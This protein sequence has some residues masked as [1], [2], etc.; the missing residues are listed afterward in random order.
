M[1]FYVRY[2]F[3]TVLR[4]KW[5]VFLES[6]KAGIPL[7]GITH[8]LSKLLPSEFFPYARE[9]RRDLRTKTE[10][11]DPL[12]IG[13]QEFDYAWLLHQKRNKH[14]WQWWVLPKDSEGFKALA[15]DR[16]SRLEMLC[17]WRAASRYHGGKDVMIWYAENKDKLQLHPE[18]RS[19]VEEQL[20]ITNGGE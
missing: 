7:C 20:R 5:F 2:L 17:D 15:M 6:W 9:F 1:R 19:W 13:S 18:T 10:Y 3:K 8:D 4:H 12:A 16:T 11:Y 14:H